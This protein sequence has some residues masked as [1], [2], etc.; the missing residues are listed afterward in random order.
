MT[1]EAL[2]IGQIISWISDVGALAT[3]LL[4][5]VAGMR[6]DWVFGWIHRTIVDSK[7]EEIKMLR[8]ERDHL[9]NLALRSTRL[10]NDVVSLTETTDAAPTNTKGGD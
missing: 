8:A 4:A 5:L 2:T 7:N 3:V 1:P 9:L 10:A 6:G